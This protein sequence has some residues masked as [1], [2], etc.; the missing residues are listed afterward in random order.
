MRCKN[1]VNRLPPHLLPCFS[2][3]RLVIRPDPLLSAFAWA[4]TGPSFRRFAEWVTAMAINGEEHTITQS[5][6]ALE[7]PA[8]WKA[9][10]SFGRGTAAWHPD[11]V[12][13]GLTRL[14]AD[15]PRAALAR[16]QSRPSMTPRSMRYTPRPLPW[17][18][19][20]LP[21]SG[22][23]LRFRNCLVLL[24]VI[25]APVTPTW[26]LPLSGDGWTCRRSEEPHQPTARPDHTVVFAG[27]VS[28][29]RG[30]L[31][32]RCESRVC[33]PISSDRRG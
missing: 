3:Q 11:Y 5:V 26:C 20:R 16:Y 29:T 8:D 24:F 33:C 14:V 7:R 30:T 2:E 13:A 32:R 12:T 10:E 1:L 18:F 25:K 31:D 21:N 9:L 6:L 17:A 4:F 27:M 22:S 28:M 19:R 23:I 15:R